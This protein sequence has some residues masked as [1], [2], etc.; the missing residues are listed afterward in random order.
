MKEKVSVVEIMGV[1]D[2]LSHLDMVAQSEGIN[3]PRPAD[4]ESLKSMTAGEVVDLAQRIVDDE[5]LWKRL[6]ETVQ[7]IGEPLGTMMRELAL[8]RQGFRGTPHVTEEI[9]EEGHGANPHDGAE[10]RD[11][12]RSGLSRLAFTTASHNPRESRTS[13]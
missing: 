13:H 1:A 10:K 12:F 9:M 4:R 2:P 3:L 6:P 5:S 8:S 7:L 11:S